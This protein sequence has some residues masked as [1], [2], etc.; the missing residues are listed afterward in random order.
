MA[1]TKKEETELLEVSK[2]PSDLVESQD[3]I[4]EVE[5]RFRRR[6]IDLDDDQRTD[7]QTKCH[8]IVNDYYISQTSLFAKLRDWNELYEGRQIITDNPWPGASSLSV[9]LPKIKGREI[10][11]VIM[12]SS[13]RPIPFLLTK[14]AGPD[15]GY[16]SSRDFVDCL[17]DFVEDKIKN[18]TNVHETLKEAII[19]TYRDGTC[20]VQLTWETDIE[21]VADFKTYSTIDDFVKD[22]PSADK[23]GI[24]E[25]KYSKI[26]HKLGDGKP[27]DIRYEYEVVNYDGPRAYIVPLIDFVHWPVFTPRIEDL[28]CF[29]K[30]VWYTDYKLQEMVNIGKFSQEDVDTIVKSG[31][32]TRTRENYTQSRDNIEGINRSA[33]KPNE[34][35]FYE[36]VLKASVTDD[37]KENNIKRKYLILY[38]Y[39]SGK[40]FYITDYPI[41]K[42]KPNYFLMRLIRRD[43][44][45]L[46]MSLVDDISDLCE[47]IDIIHRQRINS[48]TISH[49]PSFKAKATAKDKFDPSRKEFRFRPGVVFWLTSLDDVQ[50]F[51]IRPVDLSG[52]VE[53]EMMLYQLVDQVTGS[54]SGNSGSLTP[55]DPHAPARKQQEMLR[56][57]S[58][59]IDD[60]VESLLPV[61]GAIGSFVVDLYYQYGPDR[62]KYYSREE[63]GYLLEN[64]MERSKLYNPNVT[65]EV[66]GTSVFESPDQEFQRAMDID[67]VLAQNPTTM[68][69]PTIRRNSLGRILAASRTQDYKSL[70]PPEQSVEGVTDPATG[71]I[72]NPNDEEMKQKQNMQQ[73]K[74]AAKVGS[75][76][77]QHQNKMTQIQAQGQVDAGLQNQ[78]AVNDV[79]TQPAEGGPNVP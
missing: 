31:G 71:L 22:Y 14:Y 28:L 47:E 79:L 45:M 52:S 77:I 67:A 78:Q 34:Y 6:R 68:Q 63:D 66:N 9:P 20:P 33:S 1:D 70:M 42:G 41:R 35:E 57:S 59:R 24:S 40:I 26:L 60:Y 25:E 11:S 32:E 49:V 7:L 8:H 39:T 61:F 38:H 30:R 3:D 55:L 58:N 54:T 44:R 64:E 12:R 75:Q 43:G 19:P 23:A 16:E 56:Q 76:E 4:E 15:S 51:D 48:R 2:P 18:D 27:Y 29:G 5:A 72:K 46:G 74:M 10:R 69:D 36:L 13:M 62:I 50:Q 37:E 53:E 21:T 65:F 73:Q 17:E